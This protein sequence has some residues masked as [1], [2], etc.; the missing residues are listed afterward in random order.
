[1]GKELKTKVDT[2][3]ELTYVNEE[4]DKKALK[5][6]ILIIDGAVTAQESEITTTQSEGDKLVDE[7]VGYVDGSPRGTYAS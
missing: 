5:S 3:A 2:K 6:D 7:I 4:L 1:M